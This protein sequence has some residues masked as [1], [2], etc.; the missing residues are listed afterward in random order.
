MFVAFVIFGFVPL[1]S[2]LVGGGDQFA[3]SMTFSALALVILGAA[4]SRFAAI[5]WWRG[6][7]EMLLVGVTAGAASY[8][9]GLVVN[10]LVR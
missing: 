8:A 6:G 5:S 7:L 10:G 2:Y 4:R 9:I 1:L 3:V